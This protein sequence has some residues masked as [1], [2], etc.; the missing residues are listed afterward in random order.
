MP[1]QHRLHVVTAGPA[2]IVKCTGR[3]DCECEP[4]TG[5]REASIAAQRAR[6]PKQPW[7]ARPARRAA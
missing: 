3:L 5:D 2:Q 1:Q 7:R 6:R 4:C